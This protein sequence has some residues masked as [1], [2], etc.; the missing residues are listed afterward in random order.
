MSGTLLRRIGSDARGQRARAVVDLAIVAHL[1]VL[2][3]TRNGSSLLSPHYGLPDTAAL[4][5]DLPASLPA[6]QRA[7]VATIRQHEPRLYDVVTRGPG[8]VLPMLRLRFDLDGKLRDG[9]TMRLT[10]TLSHAG[11]VLVAQVDE[12][13]DLTRDACS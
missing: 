5:R 9:R 2:L 3:N 6:I 11:R 12:H 4:L 10:L 8:R 7:I 13:H 1:S